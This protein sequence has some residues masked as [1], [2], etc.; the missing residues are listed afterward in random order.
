MAQTFVMKRGDTLP[1]LPV[2]LRN[3]DNS[4]P[5]LAGATVLF[6]MSDPATGTLIANR[7]AAIVDLPTASVVFSWLAA[8]TS[9]VGIYRAEFEV[10][11]PDGHV[12]TFPNRDYLLVN[13]GPDL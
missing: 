1:A 13:I 4:I 5:N 6:K 10:T 7:T 9:V 3:P 12:A 11:F 8:E 2:L